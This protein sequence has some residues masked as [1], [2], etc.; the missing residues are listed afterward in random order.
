MNALAIDEIEEVHL[1]NI[2]SP[3]TI[4]ARSYCDMGPYKSINLIISTKKG[5][6]LYA[7]VGEKDKDFNTILIRT[8]KKKEAERKY[9]HVTSKYLFP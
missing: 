4:I 9:Y 6:T 7:V 3:Y 8:S 2:E 5:E 1:A